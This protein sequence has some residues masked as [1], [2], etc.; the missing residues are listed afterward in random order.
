MT[1]QE[2]LSPAERDKFIALGKA[3]INTEAQAVTDLLPRIDDNFARACAYMLQ[4]KGR[5]VVTGMGK[6][7]HIGNKIAATL[8]STGS[9]AFFVHPGEASHGDLGMITA[10]D[11]VLAMSNSGE[12][13][14]LVTIVPLLK[15][16][17]VPLISMTG[18]QSSTLASEAD[19][20]LDIS[21]T[22]EAC[23]LGLAPTASTT[24]TLAMGD[25]LAVA[26]L[27]ARGFTEQDFARSHPGGSLGRRLLIHVSD[28]MHGQ[29]SMP[30]VTEQAS[31]TEALMEM[32]DKGLGMTAI[33][34]GDNKLLGIFTDGD[35]RRTLDADVD[36]RSSRVSEVMGRNCVSVR[37]NIL[38]A[39][40]LQMMQEKKINALL[41][42]DDDHKLI[43][44]LNMHDLLRAGVV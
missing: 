18:N 9:P 6:S 29:D 23:P 40:A 17:G 15:R 20:A 44:A 14:E 30:K 16:L 21:V 43:G 7:G 4:C 27:E 25:A 11:V 34:D 31:L 22:K 5:I 38:A 28:I 42:V 36:I 8:A 26:L 37:Q 39:E 10:S 24:A 1:Y 19:V 12:T 2:N 33:V 3:V 13:D 35:L 41:V 32:T